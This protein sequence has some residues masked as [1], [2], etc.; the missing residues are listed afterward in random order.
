MTGTT[1]DKSRVINF[2]DA[3]F[4]IAMTLLVLEIDI[5]TMETVNKH[6]TLYILQ[7]RIPS[8]IGMIVSSFVSILYWKSHLRIMKYVEVVDAT[9]LSLNIGLL[10]SIVLL[11]F[12]T[13]LYVVGFT[14]SSPFIFYSINIS[15]IGLFNYLMVY[16]VEKTVAP[17]ETEINKLFIKR[18]KANAFNGLIWW[19]LAA[20]VAVKYNM[21]A[22][23]LFIFIFVL[24]IFVHRHFGKRIKALTIN[25]A[26]IEADIDHDD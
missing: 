24:Q 6:N 4:S 21:A 13:A 15:T 16:Y 1:Y 11:P 10:L 20:I 22:R 17:K 9:L 26:E 23:F 18:N 14:Y 7:E 2:S 12:S 25:E 8:F 19:V 3:V 5:P